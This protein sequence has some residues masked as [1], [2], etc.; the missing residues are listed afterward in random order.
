LIDKGM[1][2]ELGYSRGAVIKMRQSE[3]AAKAGSAR[4]TGHGFMLP[5]E[6]GEAPLNIVFRGAP[7]GSS[8]T[9]EEMIAS[10]DRGILV[11]RLW[12]IREVDPYEKVLT[13]MTREGT[14]LVEHGKV[15]C[16]IRNLRFNQSL[17][18]MLR[19]VESLGEAV[20]ASGE[21][22][23][24]MVVPPMKVRDFNFTETTRF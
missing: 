9:V 7:A 3:M 6:M 24:D 4:P 10:M 2:Q 13:G 5:N 21:E 15:E 14:F 12:Y 1:V 17:I 8:Q 23:I 19:N 18:Q 11:T 22:S 20:R 16:G